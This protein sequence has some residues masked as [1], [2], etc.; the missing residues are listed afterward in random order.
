MTETVDEK[1]I[2][3]RLLD[4]SVRAIARPNAETRQ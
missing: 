3:M 4:H 1:I 2:Q